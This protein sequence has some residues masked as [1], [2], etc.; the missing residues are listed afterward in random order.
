M[1]VLDDIFYIEVQKLSDIKL[2]G[3]KTLSFAQLLL[4]SKPILKRT[5]SESISESP[6]KIV[7]N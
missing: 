5:V 2:I 3:N 7:R 6:S 1:N 4:G